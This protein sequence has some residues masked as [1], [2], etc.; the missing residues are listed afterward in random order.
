MNFLM[1][2]K[3]LPQWSS[4]QARGIPFDQY[5]SWYSQIRT[6]LNE[7]LTIGLPLNHLSPVLGSSNARPINSSVITSDIPL[8]TA[9]HPS[10]VLANCKA[11][12]VSYPLNFYRK[13]IHPAFSKKSLVSWNSSDDSMADRLFGSCR[14]AGMVFWTRNSSTEYRRRGVTDRMR[15]KDE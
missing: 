10:N 9:R 12:S 2:N 4:N 14:A 8:T 1:M 5:A 11:I 13:G 3:A 7:C 15:A 6:W